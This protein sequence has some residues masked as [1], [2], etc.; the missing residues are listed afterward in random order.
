MPT[1][2]PSLLGEFASAVHKAGGTRTETM[3]R[4]AAHNSAFTVPAGGRGTA[5]WTSASPNSLAG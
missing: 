2:T 1:F 5:V 4:S 3:P